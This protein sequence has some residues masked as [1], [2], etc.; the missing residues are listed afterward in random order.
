MEKH[1]KG[2]WLGPGQDDLDQSGEGDTVET[3]FHSQA[4]YMKPVHVTYHPGSMHSKCYPAYVFMHDT[5]W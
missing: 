1:R 5:L 2:I 3:F 4:V